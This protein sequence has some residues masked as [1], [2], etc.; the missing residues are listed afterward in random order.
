MLKTG[1]TGE[2]YDRILFAVAAAWNLGAAATLIFNPDFLLAKLSVNDPNARLLA[3]SFASSVT[4]WGI[5]YALIAFDRR[6]F[7]DFAW[8]GVISKTIFFTVYAAAFFGRRISFATF[9]P[10]LVDLALAILFIEFLRRRSDGGTERR[11]EG[12]TNGS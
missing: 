2:V 3:R 6:R 4:T 9:I 5:G 1:S 11:R 8:L 12:E 7:R 10:A